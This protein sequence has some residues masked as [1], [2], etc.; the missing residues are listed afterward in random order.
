MGEIYVTATIRNPA[1]RDKAWTGRF[2]VDTGA[3]DSLVPRQHLEAIGIEPMTH[4]V[5]TLDD[6]SQVG[7]DTAAVEI[8]F[9]DDIVGATVLF[10]EA[11][12]VPIL[13]R[14]TMLTL[15]IEVNPRD[16]TLRKLPSIGLRAALA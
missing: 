4:R 3:I 11:N 10:G 5:Y 13:G 8:E 2:L 1:Q 16:G 12:T 15:G 7:M 9:M 6:G 14:I